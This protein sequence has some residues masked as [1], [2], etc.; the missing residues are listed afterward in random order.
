[1]PFSLVGAPLAAP[2]LL[3]SMRAQQVAPLQT[4]LASH[5]KRINCLARRVGRLAER[6]LARDVL[7][8]DSA[9]RLVAIYG[10][11]N[12]DGAFQVFED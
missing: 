7:S 10:E 6:H 4:L 3:P 11:I 2:F 8:L 1:M 9:G 5:K 12:K